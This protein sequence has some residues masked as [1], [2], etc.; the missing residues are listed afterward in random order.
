MFSEFREKNMG[1]N[2][3]GFMNIT[4]IRKFGLKSLNPELSFFYFCALVNF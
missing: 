2:A 4:G 3:M 1:K